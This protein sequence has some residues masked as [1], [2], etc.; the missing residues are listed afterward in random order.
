M[1]N[2]LSNGEPNKS[3]PLVNSNI[4]IEI[5]PRYWK[6]DGEAEELLNF[7]DRMT[8]CK[9]QNKVKIRKYI[10]TMNLYDTGNIF[11][12]SNYVKL[13]ITDV[14]INKDNNVVIKGKIIVNRNLKK[15]KNDCYKK[16][17]GLFMETRIDDNINLDK[18]LTKENYIESMTENIRDVEF[19]GDPVINT[20]KYYVTFGKVIQIVVK[21]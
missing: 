8:L 19:A 6:N 17:V 10:Q 5:K 4:S 1:G 9:K 12:V 7:S 14:T 21:I 15:N 11:D 18:L 2:F 13:I 20:K 3:T 16:H